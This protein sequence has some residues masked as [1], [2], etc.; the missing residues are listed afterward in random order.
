M[1]YR[2]LDRFRQTFERVRYL[3][4]NSTLGDR[5]AVELYEDLFDLQK[6][7]RLRQRVARAD[8]VVNVRNRP[9]GIRGRRGDGTF[10]ELVPGIAATRERGF[11]AGRGPVANI[12]I[13]TEVKILA[14]AMIKQIDR[15]IGDLK[16]QA[17]QFRAASINAICVAIVGVNHATYAIGYEGTRATKTDGKK[18]RHPIVE[19]PEAEARLVADAK[20]SFDEFLIVPYRATND[21]PYFF[22]WVDLSNTEAEYAASLTRISREYDRRFRNGTEEV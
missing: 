18:H 6:S 1:N 5:I 13:G 16:K 2:L 9:T 19:A 3:H 22:E 21:D 11:H 4:R 12:E 20:P 8:R 15:V 10:G 17:A 7:A 14:K